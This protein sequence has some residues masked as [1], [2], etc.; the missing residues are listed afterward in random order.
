[1]D[2]TLAMQNM[3]HAIEREYQGLKFYKVTAPGKTEW[4]MDKTIAISISREWARALTKNRG[5]GTVAIDIH[6]MTYRDYNNLLNILNGCIPAQRT[7]MIHIERGVV[8]TEQKWNRFRKKMHMDPVNTVAHPTAR[9]ADWIKTIHEIPEYQQLI[10]TAPDPRACL[11]A[12]RLA[13]IDK[14]LG[15]YDATS[16]IIRYCWDWV[17]STKGRT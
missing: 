16:A 15:G 9:H 2:A 5:S 14:S 4:A 8:V 13:G 7:Y 3:P 11:I 12:I 10:R 1:M 17:N 6:N